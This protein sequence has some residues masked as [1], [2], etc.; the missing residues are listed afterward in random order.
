[1]AEDSQFE[2]SEIQYEIKC[3]K[4]G[5]PSFETFE[6]DEAEMEEQE[7]YIEASELE[8]CKTHNQKNVLSSTPATTATSD[9]TSPSEPTSMGSNELFLRSLLS[10]LDK[11]PDDKNMRA[12]I[13]IQEVLYNIMFEWI[14]I[15]YVL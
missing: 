4:Q 5:D 1:M 8:T 9:P 14:N 7:V 2:D 12:R 13:K 3:V 11:L 15:G 6:D 10:T